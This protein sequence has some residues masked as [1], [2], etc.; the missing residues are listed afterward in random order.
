MLDVVPPNM[1]EKIELQDIQ[2]KLDEQQEKF[3][4]LVETIMR[5]KEK[6]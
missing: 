4:N 3:A 2:I 1:S 6:N 5:K